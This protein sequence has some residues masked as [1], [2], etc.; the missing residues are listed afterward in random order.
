MVHF[1]RIK[2]NL[3]SQFPQIPHWSVDRWKVCL[4]AGGA[5]KRRCQYCT[6]ISGTISYLRTHQGNSGRNLI[7]PPLKDNVVIQSGFFQHIYHI[8]CG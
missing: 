8:G 1:W 7:D 2:E 5:A 6:D 4:E 3:Q